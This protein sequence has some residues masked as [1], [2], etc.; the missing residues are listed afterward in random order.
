[1][2]QFAHSVSSDNNIV[3]FQFLGGETVL[4]GESKNIFSCI[5]NYANR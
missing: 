2:R 1:M 4:T 3:P 5:G